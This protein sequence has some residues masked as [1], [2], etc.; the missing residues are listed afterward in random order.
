[1]KKAIDDRRLLVTIPWLVQFLS[2]LDYITLR[3]NYFIDVFHMLYDVYITATDAN[4]NDNGHLIRPTSLFIIRTCLGWLFE[5]SNIPDEYH[6][7][8][9]NRTITNTNDEMCIVQVLAPKPVSDYFNNKKLIITNHQI[10][11]CFNTM[12]CTL[13]SVETTF[14]CNLSLVENCGQSSEDQILAT[15]D[16]MMENILNAACPFLRDFRVSIMPLK[17]SKTVSRSGKYRHITTKTTESKITKDT[18][19]Q[20]KLAESFLQSQS[21]SVRRT[22]EFVIERTVSAVIK[23]FQIEILI[24][25]KRMVNEEINLINEMEKRKLANEMYERF[26]NAQLQLNKKWDEVIPVMTRDRVKVSY[27][28][29]KIYI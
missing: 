19:D 13:E 3:L 18:H 21:L 12:Q 23:D 29:L 5:Q 16:P 7:Y 25:T 2:M 14:N 26:V 9:Q 8:R 4:L 24:P 6:K 28:Q 17:Y 10:N 15:F 22:I 27:L 11:H 1:M 20:T